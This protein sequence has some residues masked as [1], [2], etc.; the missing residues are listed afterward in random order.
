MSTLIKQIV[1]SDLS[2]VDQGCHVIGTLDGRNDL[3]NH[4]TLLG[5]VPHSEDHLTEQSEQQTT[6]R[7]RTVKGICNGVPVVGGA[8]GVRRDPTVDSATQD[9][10]RICRPWN[11]TV[12]ISRSRQ[13][14][15]ARDISLPEAEEDSGL[16]GSGG[17]H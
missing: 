7:I 8:A 17:T 14:R 6:V 2:H 12:G 15:T 11:T 10:G 9:F 16:W 13:A 4:E 5:N 1:T 3:T